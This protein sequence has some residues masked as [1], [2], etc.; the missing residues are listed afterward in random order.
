M[1]AAKKFVSGLSDVV[2]PGTDAEI[3]A[4]REAWFDYMDR[5]NT[6]EEHPDPKEE[7]EDL[8]VIDD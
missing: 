1:P 7:E 5:E 6:Q 3:Q 8:V 4:F 2:E